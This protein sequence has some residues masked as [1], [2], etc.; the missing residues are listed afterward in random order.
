MLYD[1]AWLQSVIRRWVGQL[2]WFLVAATLAFTTFTKF[3]MP[4]VRDVSAEAFIAAY[5]S[6]LKRSG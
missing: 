3:N 5:S 1:R 6:H 4:G 2:F